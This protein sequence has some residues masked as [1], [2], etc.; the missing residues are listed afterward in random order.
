MLK[1]EIEQTNYIKKQYNTNEV[2]NVVECLREWL[3][4]YDFHKILDFI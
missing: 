1:K 2:K 4:P 3:N